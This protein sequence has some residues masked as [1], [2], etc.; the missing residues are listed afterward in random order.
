MVVRVENDVIRQQLTVLAAEARPL[1]IRPDWVAAALRRRR[2]RV[3][4][5]AGISTLAVVGLVAV[6]VPLS[7][8]HDAGL[9]SSGTGP[10]C[11]R[12]LA[13]PTVTSGEHGVAL[14][15]SSVRRT[16]PA[17]PPEVVVRLEVAE[18]VTVRL[19]PLQVL[20]VRGDVVVDRLGSPSPSGDGEGAIGR[21]RDLAPGAP[22][23]QT[24]SG[25]GACAADWTQVWNNP[26]DYR[27]VA[28]MP[29]P[30]AVDALPAPQGDPLLTVSAPLAE[31]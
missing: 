29:M 2:R 23:V 26:A 13:A 14:T 18:P 31:R 27:L 4:V 6:I 30:R 11:G 24:V 28:V 21:V 8:S 9:G 20:V 17:L 1:R 5:A 7:A 12:E 15:I 25:P 3:V 10:K 19:T 22:Y 16:S